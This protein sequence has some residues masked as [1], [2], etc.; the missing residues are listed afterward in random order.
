MKGHPSRKVSFKIKKL[1]KGGY[2]GRNSVKSL[3]RC[4][5]LCPRLPA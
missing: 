5:A 2:V 4:W 1:L 3:Q